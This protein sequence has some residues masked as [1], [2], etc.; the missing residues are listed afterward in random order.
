MKL[1]EYSAL[2]KKEIFNSL[3]TGER[4]QGEFSEALLREARM[5]T[6]N[7]QMGSTQYEPNAIVFEFIYPSAG[8]AAILVSIKIVSPQR[9]VYLPVPGWVVQSVWQ[10]DVLGSFHFEEDARALLRAYEDELETEANSAHFGE[11]A[12]SGGGRS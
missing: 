2:K 5:R 4:P 10:G 12:S 1:G 8:E 7:P 6:A 9:I 11:D 3:L